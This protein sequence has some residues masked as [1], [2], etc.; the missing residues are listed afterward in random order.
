MYRV[1]QKTAKLRGVSLLKR[2]ASASA[3]DVAFTR[4]P[5][6]P[7]FPGELDFAKAAEDEEGEED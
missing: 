6:S 1:F 5:P 2:L 3:A 7:L 4:L